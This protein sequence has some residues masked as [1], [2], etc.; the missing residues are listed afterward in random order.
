VGAAAAGVIAQSTGPA[1]VFLFAGA[2]GIVAASV[3]LYHAH[4]LAAPNRPAAGLVR[5]S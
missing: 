4:H 1:A 3:A 2:T 5:S